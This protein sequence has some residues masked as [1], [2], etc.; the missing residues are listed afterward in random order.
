MILLLHAATVANTPKY[1]V[2]L[3]VTTFYVYLMVYNYMFWER[4]Y[5][6]VAKLHHV[7]N[8]VDSKRNNSKED[9]QRERLIDSFQD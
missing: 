9:S 2:L 4:K 3:I 8:I 5:S 6:V 1:N 7:S